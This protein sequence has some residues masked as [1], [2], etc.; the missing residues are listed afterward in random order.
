MRSL[1]D[2]QREGRISR[3]HGSGTFV[4]E[5]PAIPPVASGS[6]IIDTFASAIG[7]RTIVAIS[8]PDNS[9]F[10]RCMEMLYDKAAA[11][12]ADVVC[13]LVGGDQIDA[14]VPESLGNPL[15]FIV[16]RRDLAPIAKRLFDRGHRV[17]LVGAPR[18]GETFGVPCIHG[19]QEL[20]GYFITK[21]LIDLGHTRLAYQNEDG[22][23]QTHLRWR[24][25][26]KAIAEAQRSGLNVSYELL[27][28]S[29]TS[30]W[31]QD[32]VRAAN[33]VRRSDGPTAIVAWN[34]AGAVELIGLLSRA[35]VAVPK[36]VSV[37][38]FDNLP[39]GS[40]MHPSL[41]TV[42]HLIAQQASAAIDFVTSDEPPAANE[43]LVFAP[44]L[45]PRESTARVAGQ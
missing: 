28:T 15:G 32:G 43:R 17:V 3:Q 33:Y 6:A 26:E 4:L 1:D 31:R 25:H 8:R 40:R 11:V 22:S 36:E 34:D 41:T 19:H 35:G 27:E 12:D 42:N 2:L 23:L 9:I 24:G 29:E 30:Q 39:E 21:H 18:V 20:G 16:F 5:R 13:R 45:I 7:T 14:I 10:D 37:A 38:G 44:T